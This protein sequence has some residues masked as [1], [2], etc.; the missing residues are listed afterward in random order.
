MTRPIHKAI[1]GN[2]T[3]TWNAIDLGM[4]EEGWFM[5]TTRKGE[6]VRFE[7]FGDADIDLINR[8]ATVTVEAVLKE[9]ALEDLQTLLWPWGDVDFGEEICW[10]NMAMGAL[11][12]ANAF[13]KSLVLTAKTCTDPGAGVRSE[14]HTSEL[15]SHLAAG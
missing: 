5:E 8:G 11:S 4:T 9:W 13:A 15:Q 2:Y 12:N 6:I 7:E 10:G 1:S 3:V 14:E